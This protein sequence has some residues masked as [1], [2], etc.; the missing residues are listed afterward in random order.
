MALSD[1]FRKKGT[2]ARNGEK[3][4]AFEQAAACHGL[5]ES[6]DI[7]EPESTD[8]L[9]TGQETT[10]KLG[11]RRKGKKQGQHPTDIFII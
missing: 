1:I 9:Y 2:G 5:N 4:A 10:R 8:I 7:A 3:A 11:N 6:Q